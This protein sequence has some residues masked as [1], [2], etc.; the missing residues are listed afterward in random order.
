MEVDVDVMLIDS[1][2]VLVCVRI[3][4]IVVVVVDVVVMIL[5]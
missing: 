1:V 4:S 2:G 5:V 3:F